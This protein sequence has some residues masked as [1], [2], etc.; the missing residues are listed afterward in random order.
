MGE[1]VKQ[2]QH[3]T[4]CEAACVRLLA[5]YYSEMSVVDDGI[6]FLF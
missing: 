4:A 3:A 5:N 2:E 6:S 1:G